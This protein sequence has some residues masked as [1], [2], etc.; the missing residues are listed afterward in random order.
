MTQSLDSSAAA[1]LLVDQAWEAYNAGRFQEALSAA[2][3]AAEAATRLDDQVLLVQALDVEGWA[4]YILGDAAG[5]LARCTQILGMAEDPATRGRLDH[6]DAARMVARAYWHWVGCARFI[7]SIPLRD[8]FGVLDAAERWLAATG[9]RD[10][11]AAILSERARVH[12]QLGEWDA[13]V[14]SAQEALAMELHH[15][16]SPGYS[17]VSC[18]WSLGDFL[19]DA[20]RAAEAVPYFQAV[21]DDPDSATWDQYRGHEGLARCALAAGDLAAARREARRAVQLAEPLGD[22]ALCTSLGALAGACRAQGD[23]EA[24]WQAAACR[25][26]AA[27]RIGGHYRPW[28]ATLGAVDI[29]LD[30]ADHAT[31]RQLL[32]DL[33]IHAEA[34][35]TATGS[36]THT[37]KAASRRQRLAQA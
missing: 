25:L 13:A 1:G 11:R 26:E 15:P 34:M 8:L 22:D 17:L 28:Q 9:H 29:A 32:D 12:A 36:T 2:G 24:A 5:A 14:A 31:A 30:R 18:R 21:L 7:T 6:P 23:L 35:D 27:V 16:D 4:L 20:G 19:I 37:T 33:D 10:W 3:R